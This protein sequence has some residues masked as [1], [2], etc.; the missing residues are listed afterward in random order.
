MM[1]PLGKKAEKR[2]MKQTTINEPTPVAN[3]IQKMMDDKNERDEKK[4]RAS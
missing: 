3:L 1:R 2:K 4:I